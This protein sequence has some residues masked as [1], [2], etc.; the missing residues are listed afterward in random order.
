MWQNMCCQEWFGN[1]EKQLKKHGNFPTSIWPQLAKVGDSILSLGLRL[2]YVCTYTYYSPI[3]PSFSPPPSVNWYLN[4]INYSYKKSFVPFE[5]QK[6]SVEAICFSILLMQF[7]IVNFF[8]HL[9]TRGIQ[10]IKKGLPTL[11]EAEMRWNKRPT[12]P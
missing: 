1:S 4:F 3:F 12:N 5:I 10:F 6:R 8:W 7:K 11:S 9:G 2:T